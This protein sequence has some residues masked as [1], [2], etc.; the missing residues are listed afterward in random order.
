MCTH[1]KSMLMKLDGKGK[2]GAA[3]Y[4]LYE[5]TVQGEVK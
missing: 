1:C 5:W 3:S 2:E 4:H